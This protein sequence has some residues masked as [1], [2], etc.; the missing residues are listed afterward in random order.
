MTVENNVTIYNSYEQT[1]NNQENNTI[2]IAQTLFDEATDISSSSEFTGLIYNDQ[3]VAISD[4]NIETLTNLFGSDFVQYEDIYI[5]T[6]QAQEYMQEVEEYVLNNKNNIESSSQG[7]LEDI[8]SV[9]SPELYSLLASEDSSY[10]EPE[11]IPVSDMINLNTSSTTVQQST[12]TTNEE[13][14][15]S[16]DL[17]STTTSTTSTQ[18]DFSSSSISASG[19]TSET[20]SSSSTSDTDSE[21]E[22]LYS[23]QEQIEQKIANL[24][25]KLQKAE[26]DEKQSINQEIS[27]LNN[28]AAILSAQI[29]SLLTQS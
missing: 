15:L 3:A 16:T 27:S 9:I 1:T 29:Q 20:S 25:A 18:S 24:K 6:N 5:A 17:N 23:E 12:S 19:G 10:E 22:E 28:Q 11:Y 21:L 26:D 14:E 7:E 8:S 2:Y 4:S 13:S